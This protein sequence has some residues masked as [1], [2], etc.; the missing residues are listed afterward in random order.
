MSKDLEWQ[1]KWRKKNPEKHHQ[2]D[3][4]HIEKVR[5]INSKAVNKWRKNH[6]DK[7]TALRIQSRI[8]RKKHE[9]EKGLSFTGAQWRELKVKYGHRCLCCGRTEQQLKRLG[10][11]L[12]PDHVV[13]LSWRGPQ[14]KGQRGLILN[15]QPLCQA[16]RKGSKG[17]CN[18]RKH[19]KWID[20]RISF[21]TT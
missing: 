3:R 13:P 2:W 21:G 16:S 19:M 10:R 1:K 12:V 20:Y 8:R 5:E 18:N 11:A 7:A 6:P 14:L 9:E 4:E 17:G 15:I